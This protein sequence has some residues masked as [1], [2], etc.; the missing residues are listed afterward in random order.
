MCLIEFNL[1]NMK[2][3]RLNFV[4]ELHPT[5]CKNYFLAFLPSGK[6]IVFYKDWDGLL[7]VRVDGGT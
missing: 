2:G 4:W 3:F 5:C 1:R 7:V 6:I